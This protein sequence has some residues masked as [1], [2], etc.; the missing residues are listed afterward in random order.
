MFLKMLSINI[1]RIKSV[2]FSDK[3]FKM[4]GKKIYRSGF[5]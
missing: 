1:V 5:R 3:E 2:V 4:F